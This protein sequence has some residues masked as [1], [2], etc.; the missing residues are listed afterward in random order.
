VKSI[1]CYILD[2]EDH[3]S[4][5]LENN[6][7]KIP[8]L[9]LIGKSDCPIKGLQEFRAGKQP[10][11]LF[12]EIDLPQISGLEVV[13]QLPKDILVIFVTGHIKQAY[14][15]FE[16]NAA[17]FLLKPYHFERFVT[18][19]QKAERL[20]K[21]SPIHDINKKFFVKSGFKNVIEQ[22]AVNDIVNV[23]AFDHHVFMHTLSMEKRMLNV[24][25]KDFEYILPARSFLR[26][27]RS[28]FI[29]V[30]L[31]K[32]IDGHRVYM[33]NGSVLPVGKSYRGP[34]LKAIEDKMIR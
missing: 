12:L 30:D 31:I 2:D 33:V 23:E 27:H 19:V 34:F 6:I 28:H 20:L 25:M 4:S 26:I 5:V 10:D 13:A 21:S 22:I 3:A 29:N 7:N 15:A 32:M 18:A 14:N 11:I 16:N 9:K 1:T 17:D 24:Q 8:Y